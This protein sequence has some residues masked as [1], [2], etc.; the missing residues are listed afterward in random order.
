MKTKN[1]KKNKLLTIILAVTMILAT[2]SQLSYFATDVYA[3]EQET[4]VPDLTE[5]NYNALNTTIP[6][7]YLVANPAHWEFLNNPITRGSTPYNHGHVGYT[8]YKMDY[9]VSNA[10]CKQIRNQLNQINSWGVLVSL[11]GIPGITTPFL[12]AYF[13]S[14]VTAAS[15]FADAALL[16]KGV[17]LKYNAHFSNYTTDVYNDGYS[18]A[19]V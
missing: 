11:I 13:S 4:S 5:D 17:Q 14:Y 7:E 9:Y 18:Y 8:C 12:M 10:K 19:F 1:I 2:V 6:F 16:G 15:I 3:A